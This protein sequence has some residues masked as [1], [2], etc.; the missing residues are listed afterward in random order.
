MNAHKL[1]LRK[2]LNK[3]CLKLKPERSEFERFTAQ[4]LRLLEHN[5][6]TESEEFHKHLA[7]LI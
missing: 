6:A 2:A 7:L 1:T 4:C 3:A 5:N